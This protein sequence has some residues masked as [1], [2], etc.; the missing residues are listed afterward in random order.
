M[1]QYASLPTGVRQGCSLSPFVFAVYAEAA[2][3]DIGRRL[4]EEGLDMHVLQIGGFGVALEAGACALTIPFNSLLYAD[5]ILY[6]RQ[7]R[8][9]LRIVKTQAHAAPLKAGITADALSR[10]SDKP[11]VMLEDGSILFVGSSYVYLCK[12]TSPGCQQAKEIRCRGGHAIWQ[13][14]RR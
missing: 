8:H 9:M 6:M 14:S 3:S 2:T 13:L 1:E 4:K 12:W 10:G 7:N 5:D 11:S